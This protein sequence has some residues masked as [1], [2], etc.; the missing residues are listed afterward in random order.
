[1]LF[2]LA[3]LLA[4]VLPQIAVA[5]PATKKEEPFALI[6]VNDLADLLAKDSGSV[7]VYDANPDSVRLQKGV[8]PGAH[9]LPSSVEYDV[10][11]ELPADKSTTLVF[12]CAN[13]H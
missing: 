9:L 13:V 1:M 2:T 5:E 8:I 4:L 6:H 12:Y 7:A 3:L 11:K 10:A